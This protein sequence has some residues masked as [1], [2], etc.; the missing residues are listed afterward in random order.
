MKAKFKILL[1][2]ASAALGFAPILSGA[3]AGGAQRYEQRNDGTINVSAGFS[4]TNRQGRALQALID[5]YNNTVLK[6]ENSGYKG[7]YP[8][9]WE[10]TSGYSTSALVQGLKAADKTGAVGNLIFNYPAAASQ[11]ASFRMQLDFTGINGLNTIAPQF[12]EINK[13]IAG[14]ENGETVVLPI[15][16][17]TS[18][19]TINLPLLGS[20]LTRMIEKGATVD[21]TEA[22][23]IIQKALKAWEAA[24]EGEKA[25]ILQK[26]PVEAFNETT[27]NSSATL[28][29]GYTITDNVFKTTDDYLKFIVIVRSFFKHGNGGVDYIAS[30]DALPNDFYTRVAQDGKNLFP[31]TNAAG[32]EVYGGFDFKSY[33]TA[34]TEEYNELQ[35][36]FSKF[37]Q[38]INLHALQVGGDGSYGSTRFQ[39]HEYLFTI[40]SS[41]GLSYNTIS[42]KGETPSEITVLKT[43][44]QTQLDKLLTGEDKKVVQFF[45]SKGLLKVKNSQDIESLGF[46]DGTY[47]NH[48]YLSGINKNA[49]NH[50]AKSKGATQDEVIKSVGDKTN[51]VIFFADADNNVITHAN[52]TVTLKNIQLSDKSKYVGTVDFRGKDKDLYIIDSEDIRVSLQSNNTLVNP[53]DTYSLMAP[54]KSSATESNNYYVGQ[55]PSIIGIHANDEEDKSTKRFL[56]WFLTGTIPSIQIAVSDTKNE[57]YQNMSPF[58]IFNK[59]GNYLSTTKTFFA[60]PYGNYAKAGTIEHEMFEAFKSITSDPTHN[61]L[62]EDP[63][64]P[65]AD[66]V[67]KNITAAAKA[68]VNRVDNKGGQK[69]EDE[70]KTF[71][72]AIKVD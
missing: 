24:S 17:S 48:V 29:N 62:V 67:R 30:T 27:W 61:F 65:N 49:G 32:T 45:V 63:G 58:D 19:L 60:Q 21:N 52:G 9:K 51:F 68:I 13:N 16:K 5:Y 20:V 18:V 22:S 7:E 70:L 66:I 14:I 47:T 41:A 15:S 33:V 37:F 72:K 55:G 6:D 35:S 1:A 36:V 56:E 53:E 43:Q 50:N 46:I 12:L 42:S 57:T 8:V 39:K 40:G 25:V 4:S 26:W 3:C 11:I 54:P 38:V 34:G 44:E 59:H 2:T 28:R 69:F 71:V 64:T 23:P 10:K 31:K